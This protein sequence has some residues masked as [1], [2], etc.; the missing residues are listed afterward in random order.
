MARIL[1]IDDEREIRRPLRSLLE[2]AGHE[3]LEAENGSEGVKLWVAHRADLVI[4]DV[5]MPEKD[6]LEVILE[7]KALSPHVKIIALSA[8]DSTGSLH[9]LL[10]AHQ[11]GALRTLPKPF[12]H[13]DILST[14]DELL[15]RT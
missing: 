12:R 14:I 6:G 5:F 2:H 1:I 3:V 4:T 11:F 7:L 10:D 13:A 8:G 15:T 9:S